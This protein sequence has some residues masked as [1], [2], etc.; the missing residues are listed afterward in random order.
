ML[1]PPGLNEH[2]WA[3]TL[4]FLLSFQLGRSILVNKHLTPKQL[5]RIIPAS[6]H[7]MGIGKHDQ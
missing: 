5:G 6:K 1:Q 4:L 3:P 2:N 7:L